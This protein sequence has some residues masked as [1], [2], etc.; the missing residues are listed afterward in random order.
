MVHAF[1]SSGD[2]VCGSSPS[3][4]RGFLQVPQFPKKVVR[5]T[6]FFCIS[7]FYSDQEKSLTNL[8]YITVYILSLEM[9]SSQRREAEET[10]PLRTWS[11]WSSAPLSSSSG[12]WQII[13]TS[14]KTLYSHWK[15]KWRISFASFSSS[16]VP[17]RSTIMCSRKCWWHARQDQEAEK[18]KQQEVKSVRRR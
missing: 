10:A 7:F 2:C 6:W 9:F 18:E 16:W 15:Q 1:L 13:S 11:N 12:H 3:V 17:K 4:C 14:L 5:S 8:K